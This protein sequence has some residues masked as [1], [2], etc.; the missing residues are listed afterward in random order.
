VHLH[1]GVQLVLLGKRTATQVAQVR[2]H[3]RVHGAQVSAQHLAQ[4]K[5]APALAAL[6]TTLAAVRQHVARQLAAARTLPRTDITNE[7]LLL[8]DCVDVILISGVRLEHRPAQ[9]TLHRTLLPHR[10]R[11]LLLGRQVMRLF[12]D[13]TVHAEIERV[14]HAAA[15]L[16][17]FMSLRVVRDVHQEILLRTE[18]AFTDAALEIVA[19]DLHQS[20]FQLDRRGFRGGVGLGLARAHV[21][22]AD[23]PAQ[24]LDGGA[25]LRA[26]GALERRHAVCLADQLRVEVQPV[27][28]RTLERRLLAAV[29]DAFVALEARHVAEAFAA[30]V[31]RLSRRDN[32]VFLGQY[33]QTLWDRYS[34][35]GSAGVATSTWSASTTYSQHKTVTCLPSLYHCSC[36]IISGT[37]VLMPK[38]HLADLSKTCLRHA[39]Y[40]QIRVCI[41]HQRTCLRQI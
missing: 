3:A 21:V 31:A 28:R 39:R 32:A 4:Q 12:V 36:T 24:L 1:V 29:N 17:T 13:E 14:F 37:C 30:V 40:G 27:G 33:L 10:L 8:V 41:C 23:V 6:E 5:A 35:A 18:T 20:V 34:T 22:D 9:R 2:A 15:A 19:R 25:D 26:L 11:L 16:R 7:L 38:L